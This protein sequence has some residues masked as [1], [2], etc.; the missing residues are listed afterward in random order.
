LLPVVMQNVD[1]RND[2]KMKIRTI[3]EKIESNT[4]P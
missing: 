2:A 3:V 4:R 1:L